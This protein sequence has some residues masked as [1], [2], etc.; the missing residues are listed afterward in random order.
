[1]AIGSTDSSR[2]RP[3]RPDLEPR[4]AVKV[5]NNN[6]MSVYDHIADLH[7]IVNDHDN[8]LQNT[9][10]ISMEQLFQKLKLNTSKNIHTSAMPDTAG[11]NP[12]HDTRYYTK[13]Q[14]D[15]G[16]V[17]SY[18]LAREMEEDW[19]NAY[20][21][22]Y[23]KFTFAAGNLTT[24][25]IYDGV[26]MAVTLFTKAFTY[27]LGSLTGIVT[28]RNSDGATLTKTLAYAGTDLDSITVVAA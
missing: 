2:P 6:L 17:D 11:I 13:S 20:R 25:T 4:Q 28:T 10:D 27:T 22:Y 12:D 9:G 24:I 21:S 1:M 23:K 15:A 19:K 5:I 8:V 16:I 18:R 14:V 26:G 7:K 3:L